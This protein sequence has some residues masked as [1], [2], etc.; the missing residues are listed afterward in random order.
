LLIADCGLGSDC[1]G[2][3]DQV[4]TLTQ[5]STILNF[6]GLPRRV[7]QSAISNQQSAIK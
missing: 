6:V 1:V 5:R 2:I 3:A 4:V 7:Q